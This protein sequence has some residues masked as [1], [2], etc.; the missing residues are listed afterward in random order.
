[1]RK[2]LDKKKIAALPTA[3]DMLDQ[4]YGQHGEPVRDIFEARAKAWYYSE[5]LRDARHQ[6]GLTQQ[7]L[8][9][10]V[11]KKREYIADLERGETDMQ[12]STFILISETLGFQLVLTRA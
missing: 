7:Q 8:A 1:M 10:K 2:D 5:V 4:K 3:N 6:A 12:L 9:D 11:G